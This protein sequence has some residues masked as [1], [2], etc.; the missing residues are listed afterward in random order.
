MG[1]TAQ[2]RWKALRVSTASTGDASMSAK[3]VGHVVALKLDRL[4]RDSHLPE[5]VRIAIHP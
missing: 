4:F 5:P 3:R 1:D 2:R